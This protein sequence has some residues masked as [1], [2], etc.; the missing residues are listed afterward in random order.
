MVTIWKL[1]GRITE[2]G[3]LDIVLPSD[4]PTGTVQV[5]LQ[6]TDINPMVNGD[7][8][9]N[10]AKHNQKIVEMIR[11]MGRGESWADIDD[12]VA[13]V[14]KQRLEDEQQRGLNS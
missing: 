10:A 12:P 4:V 14:L 9:N 1:E 11:A 2:D 13:F 3:K 8:E 7:D 5:E 6:M